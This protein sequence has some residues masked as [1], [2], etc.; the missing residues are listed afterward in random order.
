MI[1]EN[2]TSDEKSK[3]VLNLDKY[4]KSYQ[5]RN[6]NFIITAASKSVGNVLITVT[7]KRGSVQKS[8]TII[9][10]EAQAEWEVYSDE[11]KYRLLSLSEFSIIV[12]TIIIKLNT[13]L[14]KI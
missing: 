6:V 13:V 14:T 1:I 11:T 8:L 7:G 5:K 10:N 12:K 9:F 4:I 2:V 3:L